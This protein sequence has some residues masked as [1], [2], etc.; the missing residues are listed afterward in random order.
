MAVGDVIVFDQ[1]L[2]DESEGLHD[3]ENDDVKMGIVG[4]GVTPTAAT[5]DPRWGAGGSTDFSAQE[6]TPGGNYST[7]GPSLSAPSVTLTGGAAVFDAGDVSIAQDG[8]NP[9][10]AYWGI[11]YNNT[12]TGKNAI[13]FVELGTAVDLTLG[14]FAVNWNG[15]GIFSKDQA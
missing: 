15:S 9:T 11:V 13:A 7:G 5:S 3:L 8:S 6:V 4:N 2:V 10:G 1:F 14:A 12:A